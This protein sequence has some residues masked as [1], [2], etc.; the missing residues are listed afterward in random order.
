[1]SVLIA[2]PVPD[3]SE[4]DY[5]DETDELG[6]VDL[7]PE[8]GIDIMIHGGIV[9][10]GPWADRQRDALQRAFA[11]SIFF[12]TEPKQ[13]LSPGDTRLHSTLI[14][15]LQLTEDTT[16]RIPTREPSKDW[17]Y[18][19]LSTEVERRYGWLD[20]TTGA[21][22]SIVYT[23]AQWATRHGYDAMLVLHLDSLEIAS[24]VNLQSFIKAKAC[25]VSFRCFS[26]LPY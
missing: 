22:S 19:S 25:K 15:N 5:I 6:N 13:R 3:P 20:V 18:D 21:N 2:G 17:I 16:L 26:R 9:K 7:P 23:Q 12:D 24:S 1:M 11:P 10:Y 4:A 8:Y 14:L